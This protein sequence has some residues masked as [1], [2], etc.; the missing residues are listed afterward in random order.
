MAS[1]WSST[2]KE[3]GKFPT[4]HRRRRATKAMK[5]GKPKTE[6]EKLNAGMSV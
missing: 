3:Q 1:R 2:G 6:N 4:R 5:N